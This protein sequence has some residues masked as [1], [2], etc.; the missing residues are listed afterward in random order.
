MSVAPTNRDRDRLVA[1]ALADEEGEPDD[2]EQRPSGRE[3]NGNPRAV[4]CPVAPHSQKRCNE[5][6]C[7]EK[8]AQS[9]GVWRRLQPERGCG[10]DTERGGDHP[11]PAVSPPVHDDSIGEASARLDDRL[12]PPG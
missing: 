3:D 2:E 7:E 12:K 5:R 8:R 10:R 4:P 9:P 11:R 1:P 6:E